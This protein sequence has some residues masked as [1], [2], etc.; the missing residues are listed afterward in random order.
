MSTMQMALLGSSALATERSTMHQCFGGRLLGTK[1]AN[2]R[3]QRESPRWAAWRDA[4]RWRAI[5]NFDFNSVIASLESA[6]ATEVGDDEAIERR[7]PK[8]FVRKVL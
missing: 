3:E 7:D 8:V 4:R 6:N 1:I 5:A 2:G